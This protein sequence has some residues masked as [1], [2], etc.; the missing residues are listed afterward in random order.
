[1]N[2]YRKRELYDKR[3][4]RDE[5]VRA[6]RDFI[7]SFH[8]LNELE[9]GS[10]PRENIFNLLE[11]VATVVY[12]PHHDL[13]FKGFYICFAFAKGRQH[14]AYINTERYL[15]GQV[16]TAA[17]EL[18]HVVRIFEYLEKK[19]CPLE[20]KDVE[21]GVSR[22]A[23]EFLMPFDIFMISAKREYDNLLSA[24]IYDSTEAITRMMKEFLVSYRAIV[25]RLYELKIFGEESEKRVIELYGDET[26]KECSI[27]MIQ[28]E[29]IAKEYAKIK[30]W[31]ELFKRTR[32]NDIRGIECP[33]N[34]RNMLGM[35]FIDEVRDQPRFKEFSK[36]FE[37]D[38][39]IILQ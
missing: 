33:N 7:K 3:Q 1:M 17:H 34:I 24:N 20:L 30:G 29:E 22:F 26:Q 25:Y 21:R 38:T 13:M 11:G 9:Y 4:I 16:F 5:C 6:I 10:P 15:Q 31:I 35:S 37:I 2:D 27:K 23:S 18:G 12:H 39:E 19:G 8:E 28:Y 36:E 32:L 14:Y